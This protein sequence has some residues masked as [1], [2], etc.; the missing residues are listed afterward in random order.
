MNKVFVTFYN[1]IPNIPQ[2]YPSRS[3]YSWSTD[4][5]YY[6]KYTPD[7][8]SR[9][10]A[11]FIDIN[12]NKNNIYIFIISPSTEEPFKILCDMYKLNSGLLWKSREK[13]HNRRYDE[14]PRLTAY[15]FY[16]PNGVEI[17]NLKYNW[18]KLDYE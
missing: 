4:K 7:P 17:P 5:S 13:A 16:W 9:I 1:N 3:I 6:K 12:K 2:F 15:V 14:N 10:N 18:D 11:F 8:F